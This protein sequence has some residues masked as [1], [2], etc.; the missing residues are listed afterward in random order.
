MS[1]DSFSEATAVSVFGGGGVGS[2]DCGLRHRSGEMVT[3]LVDVEEKLS[4]R[5]GLFS[6]S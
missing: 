6:S 1:P 2:G 4:T 3:D 5:Q